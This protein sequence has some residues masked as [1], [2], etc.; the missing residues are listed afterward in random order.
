VAADSSSGVPFLIELYKGSKL[1][2]KPENGG[3][4]TSDHVGIMTASGSD[5]NKKTLW[6]Y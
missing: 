3:Y 1:A 5:V 2:I 6:E 4:L